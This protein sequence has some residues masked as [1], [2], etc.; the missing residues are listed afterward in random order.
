MQIKAVIARRMRSAFEDLYN[1]G[2]VKIQSL[3]LRRFVVVAIISVVI[4][5]TRAWL[6]IVHVY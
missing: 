3:Y 2:R 4:A 1:P 5:V 6:S